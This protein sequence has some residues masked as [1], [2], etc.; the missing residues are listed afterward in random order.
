MQEG[1]FDRIIV[2]LVGSISASVEGAWLTGERGPV[3]TN[4]QH[5]HAKLHRLLPGTGLLSVYPR[6]TYLNWLRASL[7]PALLAWCMPVALRAQTFLMADGAQWETCTG[8]FYDSGGAAGSYSANES[9]TATLCP[10]G[11][12]GSGPFTSVTFT[13]WGVGL[14]DLSDNLVIHN[15]ANVGD[16]V[17]ATGSGLN[18]LLGQTFTSTDPSGCLTFVWTSDLLLDGTGWAAQINT[19]PDAGGN[20]SVTVCSS[21]TDFDLFSALT[22]TP[23]AGGQWTF[24]GNLVSNTFSPATSPGGVYTYTV[25]A[26]APC[27]NASATVTVTKVT[28]ANAGFDNAIEV[29]SSEAPFSMRSRLLG[30]P[31]AGGTWTLAGNAAN[32][33][34]TPASGTSGLYRYIVIGSSPCPNDTSFL[35]ITLV[36]AP[37]AGT[38]G[39]FSVCSTAGVQDLFTQLGGTPGQGGTW[40]KPGSLPHSGQFIPGTD[41]GGIY[42]YTVAGQSPCVNATATVTV[43]VQAAADPGTSGDTTVCSNGISIN[44]KNVLGTTATGTWSGPGTVTSNLYNPVTMNPGTYTFSIAATGVCPIASATVDVAEVLAPD[45]GGNG[46]LSVCS[47]GASVDLFSRL[48]GTPAVG[49]SWTAPGNVAFPTG[50]YV[51]GSSTAGTYTYTVVGTPPCASD[52]ATVVVTQIPAPFAGTNGSITLCSTSAQ[53]DMFTALGTGVTTGGTWYKPVPPGGT[54]EIGRA[55]V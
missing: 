16:P 52:A 41:I 12:A 50:I 17:L 48:S 14:A 35:T 1:I 30:T 37:S 21:A 24:G 6:I 40:T 45:A 27:V 5:R 38:S 10:S 43:T 53:V 44:L 15:G 33:Q 51:P 26:V 36:Q 28:A 31:Q 13:A 54:V 3:S 29:C 34:F 47:S 25:P 20:G 46:T 4:G 55:H 18:S 23:D 2:A 22:G 42:T 11:G 9:M 32:D 8:T 39:S 49:G 7:L 19:G